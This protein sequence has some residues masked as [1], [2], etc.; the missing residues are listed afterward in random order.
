MISYFHETGV[1]LAIM[2]LP[3][4]SQSLPSSPP[5]SS[6]TVLSEEEDVSKRSIPI[7]KLTEMCLCLA[8]VLDCQ[9]ESSWLA[10]GKEAEFLSPYHL[11]G[12]DK[13]IY[14]DEGQTDCQ[15]SVN[16]VS[17]TN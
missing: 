8:I 4:T 13:D 16:L 6:V 17:S 15:N 1:F 12:A 2:T 10:I 9:Q 11:I 3:S 14:H 7:E 5:S